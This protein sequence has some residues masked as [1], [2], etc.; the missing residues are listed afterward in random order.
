[1]NNSNTNLNI[2]NNSLDKSFKEIIE[3][4]IH[5]YSKESNTG[6]IEQN[7]LKSILETQSKKDK[8]WC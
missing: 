6:K 2:F 5:K 4:L 3:F 8:N 7:I 1:M